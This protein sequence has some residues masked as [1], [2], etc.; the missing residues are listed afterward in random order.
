MF[1]AN[2]KNERRVKKIIRLIISCE[3]KAFS[4]ITAGWL[5]R[6]VGMTPPNL[7]RAFKKE[8]NRTLQEFLILEKVKRAYSL[9]TNRSDLFIKDIA[10]ELDYNSTSQFIIAFTKYTGISPG[11]LRRQC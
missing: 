1:K 9:I 2:T 7:S 11:R 4:T 6:K 3:N 5:A 8:T 10:A